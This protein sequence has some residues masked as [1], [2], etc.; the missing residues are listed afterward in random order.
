MALPR[1]EPEQ[2][3]ALLADKK[4]R[5]AAQFAEF[6]L[7]EIE[8]FTSQPEHYRLRAEFRTWHEGDD[9]YYVMFDGDKRTPVRLD[10]CPMVSERIHDVMFKLL[11]VIRP[12][13]VLRF[14]LFQVDFLSTLSGELLVSLL[15]HRQ[16]DDEWVERVKPLREQFNIDI[17]GRARKQKILLDRDF[18]VEELN[19]KGRVYRY[20]QT[21]NG[22]TQP[23]GHVCEKM[24]EWAIDASSHAGGDLVEFYCGNGNFTLPL[25]QNFRRVVATEISKVSVRSAEWNIQENG[26]DN[27]DVLRM[28]SEDLSLI[29]KGEKT[30]RKVQGLALEECEFSTVFVDPPRCGLDEHTVEQIC[31]YEHILYISCNP[32]T[33]HDNLQQISKTHKVERFAIFDQFPYTD[34]LECGVYLTRR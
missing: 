22:F 25:A 3:D 19:I 24:I 14:K 6:D 26:I 23:N 31:E 17:I 28:P 7:P 4:A 10:S 33:L 20:Q 18:V 2:Y 9:L 1:V 15:Y 34:H 16:L 21:E 29:L 5:I 13:P 30:S 27:I 32:D 8:V 11:D 12:D